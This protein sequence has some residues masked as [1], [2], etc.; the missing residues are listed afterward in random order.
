M[1]TAIIFDLD[2]T[3]IDRQLAYQKYAATLVD[4]FLVVDDDIEKER[5]IND[6]IESDQNGY[7]SKTEFYQEMLDKYTWKEEKD[8]SELLDFW[9]SEFHKMTSL[10]P[11][12]LEVIKYIKSKQKDNSELKLGL[13]TNGSIYSQNAK[14]D[15]T[16]IRDYFDTIIVS[17][18]VKINKPDKRIFD[19]ALREL[20]ISAGKSFYIGDHPEKDIL[21][22]E[23]A[24]ITGIWMK[25]FYSWP[26]DQKEPEY[27]VNDHYE[28][29]DLLRE[30]L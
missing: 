1:N 20:N 4:E 24:G 15:H 11:G 29:M 9:H 25:H 18:T 19:M 27:T 6:L 3:L 10:K 16:G 13:I 14:I 2:N 12:A 22:A 30:I 17:G 21:G 7:R 28:L 5:T 26:K 8:I 23:N